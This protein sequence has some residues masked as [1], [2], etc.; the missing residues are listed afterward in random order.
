VA[1]SGHEVDGEAGRVIGVNSSDGVSP[2]DSAAELVEL[3]PS[4]VDHL[5]R[6]HI[7]YAIRL[8]YLVSGSVSAA[9]DIA[10]DAFIKAAARRESISGPGGFRPY[11]RAAV[12]RTARSY[13]RGEARRRGRERRALSP[14]VA[15]EPAIVDPSLIDALRQ[16]GQR[17][18]TA[19]VL[20]AWDDLDHNAIASVLRCRP[21]TARSLLSRART[22]VREILQASMNGAEP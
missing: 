17:E 2:A 7:T 16:L 4:T 8:A 18:R 13:A 10:H 19:L 22:H 9:E 21:A 11:L 5:Y 20:A 6:A 14:R 1:S 3:E 12:V 15:G